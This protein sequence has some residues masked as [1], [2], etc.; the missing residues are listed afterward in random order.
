MVIA[1][2]DI[3]IKVL[4][5]VR[6]FFEEGKE[7][8]H[9]VFANSYYDVL[10]KPYCLI[11]SAKVNGE[12]MET[13]EVNLSNNTIVQCRGRHNQDSEYH[14]QMMDLMSRNMGVIQDTW[15]RVI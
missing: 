14:K 11:L 4:Q 15:K 9:C 1:E 7:M 5:S 8:S 2:N 13:I 12:R 3:E 6:E 10:K